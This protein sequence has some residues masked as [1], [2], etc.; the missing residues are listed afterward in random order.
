M[1]IEV[2]FSNT[3]GNSVNFMSLRTMLCTVAAMTT[4]H[5]YWQ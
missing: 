1:C 5:L 3:L 4:A 2:A